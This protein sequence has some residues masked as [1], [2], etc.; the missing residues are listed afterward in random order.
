MLWA[1]LY[2]PDLPL[3]LFERGAMARGPLAIQ[4]EGGRIAACNRAAKGFGVQPGMT[5][6]AAFALAP[7]LKVESRDLDREAKALQGVALWAYQ[8]TST[9]SLAIPCAVLAE[10]GASLKLFGG[11]ERL[12]R[13]VREGMA[14][15]GYESV[16]TVA[17]TPAGALLLSRAGLELE[18]TSCDALTLYAPT[19]AIELLDYDGEALQALEQMGVRT[20]A[21]CLKLPR[22]ALA[23]RFGQGLLDELDRV[24]GRLPDLREPF[25]P[26]ERYS[27]SISLPVPV[28]ETEPLLFAL[29]RQI[30]ELCGFLSAKNAGVTRL[31][32]AL[33]HEDHDPTVSLLKLSIPSRDPVHLVSLFRERLS[34]VELPEQVEGWTLVAEETAQLAPRHFSL[35]GNRRE[36]NENRAELIERLR[37][38]LGEQAVCSLQL[39]PDHRPEL[40]YREAEPG[41]AMASIPFR[42]RPL[43]LLPQPRQL[44]TRSEAPWRDGPLTLITGPERIESGWWD[45]NGVTRDYFVAA[46]PAGARFWIF[47]EQASGWFLHGI[48]A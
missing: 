25:L 10:I 41:E 3:Q 43:W 11:L 31:S 16:I 47:R 7:E 26:P 5:V 9:L 17:P 4:S 46:D 30:V 22:D 6:S 33:R 18:I 35:F 42:P 28:F 12:L 13:E 14:Q 23:R 15:L 20:L 40:A 19:L 1:S 44:A 29:K 32:L 37:A 36:A 39:Y 27:A 24:L 45:G 8:F 38:R 34:R 2:F 48:F 21:D